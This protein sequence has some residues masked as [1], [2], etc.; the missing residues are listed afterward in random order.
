MKTFFAY[1][2]LIAIAVDT[3]L[4]FLQVILWISTVY[5]TFYLTYEI[6]IGLASFVYKGLLWYNFIKNLGLD[7]ELSVVDKMNLILLLN[8]PKVERFTCNVQAV[9]NSR[10]NFDLTKLQRLEIKVFEA[11]IKLSLDF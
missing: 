2:E 9:K 6:K 4:L 7:L 5:K 10:V 1:T 3:T 8:N 11:Y